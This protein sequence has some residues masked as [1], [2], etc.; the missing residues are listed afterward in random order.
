MVVAAGE[1]LWLELSQRLADRVAHE[2]RNPLNG[3]AVNLEVVRSRA[4]RP[5]VEAAS[6]HTFAEAAGRELARAVELVEAVLALARPLREPVDL[7]AALGPLV[8]LHGALAA[9]GGEGGGEVTLDRPTDVSVDVTADPHVVRAA[10]AAALEAATGA[11]CRVRCSIARHGDEM[12]VY[13][14]CH[15]APAAPV[16]VVPALADEVRT[17]LDDAGVA[18][19]SDPDGI[20]LLF[21][22]RERG[23][24]DAT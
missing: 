8:V 2:I 20:T 13:M 21:A 14:Q 10:L 24:A 15:A 7:W 4:S 5:G 23:A 9:A 16:S 6:V 22:A 11:A 12:T 17:M 1:A 18:V 19:R 3:L